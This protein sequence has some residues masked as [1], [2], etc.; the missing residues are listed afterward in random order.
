MEGPL[1]Q[2]TSLVHAAIEPEEKSGAILTPLFLSTT[3]V[4]ESVEKYL[5]TRSAYKWRTTYTD[6][7]EANDHP[8][9]SE[10]TVQT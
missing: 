2:D 6:R 8:S 7:R 4:Q 1:K 3:F 9:K 10:G 5:V